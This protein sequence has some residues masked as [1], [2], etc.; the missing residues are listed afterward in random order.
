MLCYVNV[1]T[2][3]EHEL[4]FSVLLVKDGQASIKSKLDFTASHVKWPVSSLSK[5]GPITP[6]SLQG[7]HHGRVLIYKEQKRKCR[8]DHIF[9]VFLSLNN[10]SEIKVTKQNG[11]MSQ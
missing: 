5:V 8:K 11:P 1:S 3:P 4:S 2:G 7:K 9:S 10:D 6:S